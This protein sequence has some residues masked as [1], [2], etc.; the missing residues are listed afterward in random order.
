MTS[1]Q[2]AGSSSLSEGTPFLISDR[3]HLEEMAPPRRGQNHNRNNN[4]H[5][6]PAA[7][8]AS[9][10]SVPWRGSSRRARRTWRSR[11]SC[12]APTRQRTPAHRAWPSPR[13]S[14]ADRPPALGSLPIVA[15]P[16]GS[17]QPW[18][19]SD[20]PTRGV[21]PQRHDRVGWRADLVWLVPLAQDLALVRQGDRLGAGP[22]SKLGKDA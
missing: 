4:V 16:S 1:D 13:G 8:S 12:A 17:R 18:P 20:G 15:T 19:A 10:S 22:D 14:D 3:L 7:P 2:K 9:R 21:G 5:R 11:P 6:P